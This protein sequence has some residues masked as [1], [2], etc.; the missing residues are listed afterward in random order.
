MTAPNVPVYVGW[1][2]REEEAYQVCRFSLTR[3][4]SSPVRVIGLRQPSLRERKVYW[5]DE[6][7]RASTEFCYTRFLVPALADYKG[8]AMFCDCD[9]LWLADVTKLWDLIDDRYAIMCV[10][11]DHRPTEH[12]KMDGCEQS[13]YPRKNWSS[14]MLLNCAHPAMRTL[15]TDVVNQESGA[16]L[17]RFQWLPDELIGELPESWNWLEGWSMKPGQGAPEVVHFTRGGPWF[18]NWQNV[19]YGELWLKERD[20]MERARALGRRIGRWANQAA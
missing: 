6:D 2:S 14:L 1:D 7:P 11:H 18:E 12:T 3:R 19:D 5:R 13:V 17:H 16:F 8:W 15:T 20:A 10:K 9:F 4:T